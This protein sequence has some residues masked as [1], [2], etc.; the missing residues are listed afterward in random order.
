MDPT[1]R[2]DTVET[3]DTGQRYRFDGG[4]Q[5]HVGFLESMGI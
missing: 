4:G 1:E 2:F 3:Q 5:V